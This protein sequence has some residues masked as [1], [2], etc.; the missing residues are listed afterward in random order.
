MSSQSGT[1]AGLIGR[2]GVREAV[3][4]AAG[5]C[6]RHVCG[7]V[8]CAGTVRPLRTP[9]PPG[10]TAAGE[11]A[12]AAWLAPGRVGRPLAILAKKGSSN[13]GRRRRGLGRRCPLPSPWGKA[14][15]S[16]LAGCGICRCRAE[17]CGSRAAGP[18]AA[19]PAARGRSGRRPAYRQLRPG[20]RLARRAAGHSC[21]GEDLRSRF[22]AQGRAVDINRHLPPCLCVLAR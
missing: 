19:P 17:A 18:S 22:K 16:C 5:V 10:G 20:G 21:F 4:C 2:P 11:P 13:T 7:K 9:A 6:N 8:C 15:V 1:A 12:R 14:G 3:P